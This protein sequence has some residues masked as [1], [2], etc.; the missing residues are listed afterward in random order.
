M[1]G[2]GSPLRLRII[3]HVDDVFSLSRGNSLVV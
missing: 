2:E 3:P 1:R